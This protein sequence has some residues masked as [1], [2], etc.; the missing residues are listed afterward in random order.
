M[1]KNESRH[2][3]KAVS[4]RTGLSPHLIRI[5][6]RR[7]EAVSPS[8]TATNR[9]LYSDNDIE[10]LILLRQATEAGE[11]IGQ[12]ANLP[13]DE[14]SEMI[15]GSI[16]S[17][18]A[19]SNNSNGHLEN[20]PKYFLNRC[21][22]A[23]KALDA[24]L[25]RNT[26]LKA[27]VDLSQPQL[28]EGLLEPL[29]YKIGELWQKGDLKVVH[30]HIASAVVRSFLGNLIGTRPE[31][32]NAPKLVAATPAGQRHEFGAL[33]ATL[34]ALAAGWR[35]LYLG[36][37]LP[38]E[39]IAGAAS[40]NGTKI[41]ALSLVYPADDP[42]LP[43]ELRKLRKLL[44]ADH[45]LLIGG[46]ASTGYKAVIDEIGAVRIDNLSQLTRELNRIRSTGA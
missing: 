3:I 5:W 10:R 37:D 32:S 21:I 23:V 28:L 22:E 7:Y 33:I 12:V 34:T 36:P 40:K 9:R 43:D 42:G 29:M 14:L 41:I 4:R 1:E 39:D 18:V 25:L 46:R 16:V 45:Q 38:A 30:E 20:G 35:V 6:E 8:R 11:S 44:L 13:D 2:T 17:K 15:Q 24:E 27:S 26:L 19:D 31:S